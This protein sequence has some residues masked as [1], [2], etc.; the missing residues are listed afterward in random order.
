MPMEP[1]RMI[2]PGATAEKE[3]A[4]WLAVS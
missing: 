3:I 2:K 4:D 1:L